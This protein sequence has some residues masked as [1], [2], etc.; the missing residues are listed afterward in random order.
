MYSC[1]PEDLIAN[2]SRCMGWAGEGRRVMESYLFWGAE[3]WLARERQGDPGY[4]RAFAR[5]LEQSA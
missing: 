3:Y 5:V 2:Y 1:R 4:L